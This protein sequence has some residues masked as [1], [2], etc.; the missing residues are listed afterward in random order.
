MILDAALLLSG[1]VAANGALT[2][3]AVNGAGTFV[4]AHTLD[5]APL[6][7]GGTQ[8]GTIGADRADRRQL[9]AVPGDPG[10]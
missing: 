3:Q 1:S 2:G 9:G 10:R 8:P 7:L 4:S 5:V 6:A